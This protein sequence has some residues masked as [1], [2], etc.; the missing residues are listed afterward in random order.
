[1]PFTYSP[2]LIL[3]LARRILSNTLSRSLFHHSDTGMSYS[4]PTNLWD[5]DLQLQFN[6]ALEQQDPRYVHTESGRGDFSLDAFFKGLGVDP[7]TL[8]LKRPPS[9][10]YSLFCGHRG[11]GKSTELTRIAGKL[12][13]PQRFFV[14][15]LDATV[16][17]DPHNLQYAD[18]LMAAARGLFDTMVGRELAIPGPFLTNLEAWFSE[19]IERN[20]AT[21]ELALQVRAGANASAG[22]PLIGRLFAEITNAFK[23][24]STFKEELRKVIKNS[25]SQFATGFNRLITAAEEIIARAGQGRKLLFVIDGTDRLSGEDSTRFFIQDVVQLQV[26]ESNFVY[27]APIHLLYEGRQTQHTFGH[28]ILPMIKLTKKG[29]EQPFEPGYEVLREMVYRRMDRTLFDSPDTVRLLIAYS[30]GSPRELLK[31]LHY[32]FLRTKGERLDR[33]A[34]EQAIAD[35][36]TDYRR[37]LDDED[38]DLLY[39]IDHSQIQPGSERVRWLLY[40]LALL[41]YNSYWWRSHPVIRDLPGYRRQADSTT[42]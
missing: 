7:A 13:H 18:V 26:I 35:L 40:N 42:N 23:T 38:Y 33:P 27:C 24:N 25:F 8:E 6:Q 9:R 22:L 29:G 1:V 37:I 28:F 12:H 31:L 14:V 20:E 19:R 10:V 15:F 5:A 41:E 21:R 2:T 30:G 4:P 11:C 36:A 39:R 3:T 16:D 17:L 32:A 34:A